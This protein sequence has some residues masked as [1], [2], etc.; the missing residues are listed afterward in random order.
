MF[1]V[2]ALSGA[3]HP[4]LLT[5]KPKTL[6]PEPGGP[7]P[8]T[9]STKPSTL[10]FEAPIHNFDRLLLMRLT[11]KPPDILKATLIKPEALNLHGFGMITL[12]ASFSS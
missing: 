7:H 6:N 10:N 12:R 11:T 9:R 3:L 2:Y 8:E 5:L 1:Q 4:D